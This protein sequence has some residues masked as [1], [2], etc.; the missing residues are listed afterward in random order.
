MDSITVK[1]LFRRAKAHEGLGDADAALRDFRRVAELEPGN[2]AAAE[3]LENYRSV[4][5]RLV[6][7][8]NGDAETRR[9]QQPFL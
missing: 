1:A 6:V 4:L 7:L 9:R 5:H 8:S 3:E 2:A